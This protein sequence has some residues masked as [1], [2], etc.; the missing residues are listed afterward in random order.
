MGNRQSLSYLLP[1]DGYLCGIHVGGCGL[2]IRNRADASLDHIFTKSFFKDGS[3]GMRQ[4]DYNREWNWQPMHRECNTKRAG[5][6]YG[7]PLFTCSCHWL[8]INETSKG[9]VLHLHYGN[10]GT[11]FVIAVTSEEFNFVFNKLSTGEFS[12]EFGG[13]T[14]V[15]VSSC[16]TMGKT[17]PGKRG[18]TGKGHLGH[19]LPR[20]APEEVTL[21]NRLEIQRIKG[22]SAD[23]IERFNA[24]MD[25]MNMQVYFET[26]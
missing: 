20:I 18:I 1:R 15:E 2:P 19:A 26:R 10:N 23:S 25:P 5:Q 9:H 14:E 13:I 8:Q 21:F 16:W 4:R 11:G 12:S 24:R 7:F 17:K 3:S 6:I 22:L